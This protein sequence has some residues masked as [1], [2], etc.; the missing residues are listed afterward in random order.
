MIST[1]PE[2]SQPGE[3]V[4]VSNHKTWPHV[5]AKAKVKSMSLPACCIVSN[6]CIYTTAAVTKIREKSVFV[7]VCA[8][9]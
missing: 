7:F 8:L 2:V 3:K 9:I 1:F 6:L 5:R 4:T